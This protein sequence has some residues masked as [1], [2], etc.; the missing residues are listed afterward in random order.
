M[1]VFRRGLYRLFGRRSGPSSPAAVKGPVPDT[2]ALEAMGVPDPARGTR[3]AWDQQYAEWYRSYY[4][5]Q[6]ALQQP[7][8]DAR[9][10]AWWRAYVDYAQRTGALQPQQQQQWPQGGGGSP[11]KHHWQGSAQQQYQQQQQQQQQPHQQLAQQQQQQQQQPPGSAG[12]KDTEYVTMPHNQGNRAPTMPATT[13]T[14]TSPF[15]PTQ[16]RR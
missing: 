9:Y 14:T 2:S 10:A 5:H 12:E 6:Q 11:Q 7:E 13:T 1:K 8:W 4:A 16:K 15:L 3:H